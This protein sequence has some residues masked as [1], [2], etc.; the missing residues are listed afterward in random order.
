MD[1]TKKQANTFMGYAIDQSH[2]GVKRGEVAVGC[3]LVAKDKD[4]IWMVVSGG[5][6][7]TNRWRLATRHAEFEAID[8]FYSRSSLRDGEGPKDLPGWTKEYDNEPLKEYLSNARRICGDHD[9]FSTDNTDLSDLTLFVTCE[10]CIMCTGAIQLVGIKTVYYGCSNPRFGGCGG[11]YNCN[12]LINKTDVPQVYD[13]MKTSQFKGFHAIGGIRENETV[14][15]LQDFYSS[16]NPL[17]PEE[18]R[19]RPLKLED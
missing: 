7:A 6:N 19:K 11:T 12:R 2:I 8:N 3:V 1:I 17:A 5:H 18:I 14:Q 13:L 4:G 16:G 10:P 15:L 9:G